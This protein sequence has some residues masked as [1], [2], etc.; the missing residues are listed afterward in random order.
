[1]LGQVTQVIHLVD[2][3]NGKHIK[4]NMPDTPQLLCSQFQITFWSKVQIEQHILRE[5]VGQKKHAKNS[6]I[7]QKPQIGLREERKDMY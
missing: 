6:K 2:E 3:N 4:Y 1:M 5:T 7:V